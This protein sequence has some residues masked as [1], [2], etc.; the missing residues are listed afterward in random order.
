MASSVQRNA[1]VQM[2]LDR[3]AIHDLHVRYFGAIDA[4]DQATVRRCFTTDVTAR[5][6]GRA[7]VH[8]IDA[9]IASIAIWLNHASGL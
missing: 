3:A 4:G 6:H 5:Y 9:L 1:A 2:L 8:G 7:P